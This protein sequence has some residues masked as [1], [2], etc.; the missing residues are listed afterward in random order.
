MD[1]RAHIDV[2]RGVVV[3]STEDFWRKPP[4]RQ[5][6]AQEEIL[7][8]VKQIEKEWMEFGIGKLV[9]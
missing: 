9:L 6:R 5:L 4:G 7:S 2:C 3:I 8:D 1:S